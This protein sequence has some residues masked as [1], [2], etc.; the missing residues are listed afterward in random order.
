MPSD[1]KI[2]V[3]EQKFLATIL[4]LLATSPRFETMTVKDA[5]KELNDNIKFED[6]VNRF[7]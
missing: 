1:T 2:N 5:L 7:K 3:E 4:I 6:L